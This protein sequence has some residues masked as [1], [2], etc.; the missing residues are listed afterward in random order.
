MSRGRRI[1]LGKIRPRPHAR[2]GSAGSGEAEREG[3]HLED[4]VLEVAVAEA[5]EILE[6]HGD[7]GPAR[8]HARQRVLRFVEEELGDPFLQFDLLASQGNIPKGNQR[9]PTPSRRRPAVAGGARFACAFTSR[10]AARTG[11]ASRSACA[12]ARRSCPS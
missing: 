2:P 11:S 8:V 12:P 10:T 1:G 4:E 3:L 6:A 7:R 9:S 5:H